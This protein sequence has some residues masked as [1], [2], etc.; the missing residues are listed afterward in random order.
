MQVDIKLPFG[1]KNCVEVAT[2]KEVVVATSSI[3]MYEKVG[4]C[5]EC[6]KMT[7]DWITYN[8]ADSSCLCRSCRYKENE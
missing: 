3:S 5:T 1:L 7:S 8:G 6:G 2:T 4:K